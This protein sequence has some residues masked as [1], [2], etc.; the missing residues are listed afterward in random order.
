MRLMN[1]GPTDPIPVMPSNP[2]A[3]FT[4]TRRDA[5]LPVPSQ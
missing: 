2:G 5:Q 4:V 3:V 1:F